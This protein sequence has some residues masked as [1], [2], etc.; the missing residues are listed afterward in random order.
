MAAG[1][2]LK[3]IRE[4]QK[5]KVSAKKAAMLIGVD[6]DRYTK[7]EQRDVNPKDSGDIKRVELYFNCNIDDLD[8]IKDFQF[9]KLENVHKKT[10]QRYIPKE[11]ESSQNIR[12]AAMLMV[13]LD[14]QAEIIA[15]QKKTAV[16]AVRS[17]LEEAVK[18]REEGLLDELS[19]L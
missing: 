14:A 4:F 6:L 9:Y 12:N 19:S 16:S 15:H 18:R 5:P 11:A 3:R 7:W 2:E 1:K 8:K 10:S 17:S 13:V